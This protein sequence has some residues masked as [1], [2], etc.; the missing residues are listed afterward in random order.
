M[1]AM[2]VINIKQIFI[3]F[4][5]RKELF[6]TKIQKGWSVWRVLLVNLWLIKGRSIS[7]LL[8]A[9][10][11]YY[12]LLLLI[13]NDY[14][15]RSD[16]SKSKVK[17]VVI[18]FDLTLGHNVE[19]ERFHSFVEARLEY[20]RILQLNN[21]YILSAFVLDQFGPIKFLLRSQRYPSTSSLDYRVISSFFARF[22]I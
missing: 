11:S 22:N 9:F 4:P 16:R 3:I 20:L 17:D 10:I 6:F 14:T 21:L 15:R 12:C 8:V 18:I 7:T 19:L 13:F 1:C 5:K 2:I